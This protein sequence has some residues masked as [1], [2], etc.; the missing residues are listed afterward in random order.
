MS[1]QTTRVTSG[2]HR[3]LTE[4]ENQRVTEREDT[5]RRKADKFKKSD[6]AD[7]RARLRQQEADGEE[8]DKDEL[9]ASDID[10]TEDNMFTER[11]V[12]TK[13]SAK[14]SLAYRSE[15]VP[16][17]PVNNKG[18]KRGDVPM[19]V[20][21]SDEDDDVAPVV[22][23]RI[24]P[25]KKVTRALIDDTENATTTTPVAMC[26]AKKHP[27]DDEDEDNDNDN[28]LLSPKYQKSTDGPKCP[29][30]K[31]FDDFT[32]EVLAIAISVFRCKVSSKGPFPDTS[33]FETEMAQQAWQEACTKT[34]LNVALTPML[35]KMI[36]KRTSHVRGELKTKVR[37]VIQ[38][39]FG[40]RSGE[41]KKTIARNRQHAEDLKDGYTFVY[42]DMNKKTGLY[43]TEIIQMVIN[44]MWF[45]NKQDEGIRYHEYFNPISDVTIALVLAAIECGIDEWATGI[46]EDIA[47]SA[48]SYK[49]VYEAHLHCLEDF[50]KHTVKYGIVRKLREMLHSNARFHS[51][52]EPLS[53]TMVPALGVS[54]FDAAIREW[55]DPEAE[56]DDEEVP[57]GDLSPGI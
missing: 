18:P 29:R 37:G 6:K 34:G 49:E 43:K 57:E 50:E 14:K 10:D 26:M 19:L 44:D 24:L 51:G 52:A 27:R 38:S 39:F 22:P 32:Q 2:R 11:T 56:D 35:L 7:R 16:L 33:T 54:A 5:I 36:T 46:K 42:A 31:D 23:R 3:R 28:G 20:S 53:K 9:I 4:K 1:T 21:S 13:L 41:N 55:E 12:T 8:V 40:F 15:K 45:A 47:F 25:R 17:A 30:A 48:A